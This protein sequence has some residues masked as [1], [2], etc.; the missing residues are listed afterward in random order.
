MLTGCN[1]KFEQNKMPEN[2]DINIDPSAEN[3]SIHTGVNNIGFEKKEFY[4]SDMTVHY[5][6]DSE[7]S[8]LIE[9]FPIVTVKP[10]LLT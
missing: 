5:S 4:S 8:A 3:N 9:N 1:S 2:S 10:H 7:Y 6:F